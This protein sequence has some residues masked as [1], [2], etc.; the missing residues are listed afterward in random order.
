MSL[1][2]LALLVVA[3]FGAGLIG[4]ITG[5]ASIVSYPALLAVGLTPIAA[6]V[7]NTVALVAVGVGS[8]AQSGKAL[9]DGDRRRL[10]IGLI[11]A[12]IGGTLGAVLLLLTPAE[13]FEAL[14][15]FLVAIAAIALLVQPVLRRWATSHAERPWIF[16][17]GLTL[18]CI[19]GGYFGAGAGIMILA[20]MLVVTSEPL[21]R[22]AL[23][24]SVFL[25]VA[26]AVAA[27]G[28]MI[29]GPVDWWAA[30][31]MAIGCL[32]G[33]WC[34]PPVVKR[35]PAGPLRIVVGLCGLGLAVWLAVG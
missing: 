18:I 13:A 25:G 14:V 31:A 17:V 30:L 9:L 34:G 23:S 28:F 8:T 7:T 24:K 33:G 35:L 12:L 29:F 11:A 5:L 1:T 21:W 10:V 6:N 20:L 2:D 4:Y 15:P 26:N 3:G 22:A 32:L 19:Y 27:V 16:V